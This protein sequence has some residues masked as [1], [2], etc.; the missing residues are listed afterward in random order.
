MH[1]PIVCLLGFALS[2]KSMNCL[3]LVS[4]S[5]SNVNIIVLINSI[6]ILK[7]NNGVLLLSLHQKKTVS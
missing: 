2:N 5:G 4:S 7:H 6:V 3:N 1:R